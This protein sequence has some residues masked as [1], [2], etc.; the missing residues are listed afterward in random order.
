MYTV[1]FNM[2]GYLPETE[3]VDCETIN[4]ARNVVIDRIMHVTESVLDVSEDMSA[5]DD[6]L[7]EAKRI[8][9]EGGWFKLPDGYV[10]DVQK[11]EDGQ[12]AD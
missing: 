12:N 1:V 9:A 2:P 4:E 6:A 10:A 11:V 8:P 3:P 7:D 5:W